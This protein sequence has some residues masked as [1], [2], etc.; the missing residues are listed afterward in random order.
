MLLE[1]VNF[2]HLSLKQYSA[3]GMGPTFDVSARGGEKK[4][5]GK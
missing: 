4:G 1:G 3:T 5:V 2:K